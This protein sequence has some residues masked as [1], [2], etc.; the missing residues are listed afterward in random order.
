MSNIEIV[1]STEPM[2]PVSKPLGDEAKKEETKA[3]AKPNDQAS[4]KDTDQE[5]EQ[6][7]ASEENAESTDDEAEQS[8]EKK[9]EHKPKKKGGFQKRIEKFNRLLAE[10]DQEIERLRSLNPNTDPVKE[11]KV[12][13]KPTIEQ[14][15][16]IA[17]YTEALTEWKLEQRFKEQEAKTQKAQAQSA[18]EKQVSEFG[19]K[20]KEFGKTVPDFDDLI[21]ENDDFVLSAGLEHALMKSKSGPEV[22]YN[23]VKNREELERINSLS[24]FDQAY[25]IASLE[26][27][28]KFS[29]KEKPEI[30]T[31]TDAPPPLKPV[32][33]KAAPVKKSLY[34]SDLSFSDYEKLREAEIKAQRRRG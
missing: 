24:A 13:G 25:E 29:K 32:G 7:E 10:R 26:A 9:E 5:A 34:D 23:L 3:E 19:Q 12:E 22:L 6:E 4:E 15:D 33:A 31:K 21:A 1:S 30:K 18:Y 17:E 28:L 16:S 8:D 20:V 2:E 14:F 27:E 11:K